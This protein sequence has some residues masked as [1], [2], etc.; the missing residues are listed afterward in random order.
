MAGRSRS[1]SSP[2]R[3]VK[4]GMEELVGPGE[5]QRAEGD[6]RRIDQTARFRPDTPDTPD[7]TLLETM[8][9]DVHGWYRSEY[10]HQ[11][12]A[13]D[14]TVILLDDGAGPASEQR[15]TVDQG[16]KFGEANFTL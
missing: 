14:Y 11:G 6:C 12:K 7:G 13:A 15:V 3:R 1:L 16:I 2:P 8:A 9:T 10:V 4:L 5:D